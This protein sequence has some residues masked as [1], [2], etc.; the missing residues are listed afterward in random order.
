MTTEKIVGYHNDI[1]KVGDKYFEGLKHSPRTP[2]CM[3]CNK[4]TDQPFR[5][6]SNK[7]SKFTIYE[8]H[9]CLD[10]A[11]K[12]EIMGIADKEKEE[13]IKSNEGK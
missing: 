4:I 1:L 6:W 3:N 9:F 11:E 12:L 13:N 8:W 10:C 7:N 5:I 2:P